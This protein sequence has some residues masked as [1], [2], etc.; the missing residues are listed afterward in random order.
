[1][2][3]L[4]GRWGEGADGVLHKDLVWMLLVSRENYSTN[5]SA[6]RGRNFYETGEINEVMSKCILLLDHCRTVP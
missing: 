4:K 2:K 3:D 5:C 1:M 6:V